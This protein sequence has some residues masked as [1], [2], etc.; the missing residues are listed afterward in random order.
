MIK[1]K[2]LLNANVVGSKTRLDSLINPGKE[3]QSLGNISNAK[4]KISIG[5]ADLLRT[6]NG[7]IPDDI[8]GTNEQVDGVNESDLV[9]TDGK[10]I[11]YVPTGKNKLYVANIARNA[12]SIIGEFKF[13]FKVEDMYITKDSII[14][15]GSKNKNGYLQILD[16]NTLDSK[17]TIEMDASIEGHRMVGK[18]LFLVGKKVYTQKGKDLRPVIF[19]DGIEERTAYQ[20]IFYF[21][22]EEK[23]LITLLLTVNTETFA[24]STSAYL[25][26][27][28]EHIYMNGD[29]FFM[30]EQDYNTENV[31]IFASRI[32]K[33]QVNKENS[34]LTYK[35]MGI[36]DGFPLNQYSMDE[37]DGYLRIVTTETYNNKVTNRLHILEENP[38]SDIMEI[39]ETLEKGIGKTGESVRSVRFAKTLVYITTFMNKRYDPVYTIDISD[40]YNPKFLS[41]TEEDGYN[42]YLHAWGENHLIGIGIAGNFSNINEGIKISAYKT[43]TSLS[44][45][46]DRLEINNYGTDYSEVITNPKSL[47]ISNDKNII[48]FPVTNGSDSS[49]MLYNIDFAGKK[50]ITKQ[51][52]LSFKGA[53][54]DRGIYVNGLIYALTNKGINCY[55]ID[56]KK[57]VDTISL[58]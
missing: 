33:F 17:H 53:K 2:Q 28:Y 31:K 46:I 1:T 52:E 40:V 4:N 54:I 51:T 41:A 18:N 14:I 23:N 27:F 7:L 8:I 24:T 25:G 6:L 39:V 20:D 57:V 22:E 43:A 38:K 36:V 12:N 42:T 49:F 19:K 10:K 34:E 9:K 3:P 55:D 45:P 37:Y 15:M 58:H 44:K 48:G 35:G 16:R 50:V 29:S 47:L 11:F 30:L 32:L 56:K 5:V 26:R 13:G 21:V